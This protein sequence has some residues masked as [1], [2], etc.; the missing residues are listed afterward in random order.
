MVVAVTSESVAPL[1]AISIIW[2]MGNSSGCGGGKSVALA[3]NFWSTVLRATSPTAKSL[4]SG[5]EPGVSDL[6][7]LILVVSV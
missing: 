5:T 3:Y 4:E 7:N 1:L 6:L 2:G